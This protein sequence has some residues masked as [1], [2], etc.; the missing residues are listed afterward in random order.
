MTDKRIRTLADWGVIAVFLTALG[1]P[2]LGAVLD[3]PFNKTNDMRTLSD[4]PRLRLKGSVLKS[5]PA[6]F[7]Q[8]WSDHFGFRGAL[9]QALSVARIHWLHAP[10]SAPVQIGRSSW[11]YYAQQ[12]P[13]MDYERVRPFT[14]E[15]LDRWQRVLEQRCEWLRQ[16][17]CRYLLFIPPDKQTIYPEYVDPRYRPKTTATRLEQL[18]TH[19]RNHRAKVDFLDIR[20]ELFAAKRSERLYHRTDSHWN[21]Y[22]AFVGYQQLA[23]ALTKWFP[24]I[25]PAPRGAFVQV[26]QN[27]GG[28][29]LA[30]ILSLKEWDHE[31]WLRL[32][33]RSPLKARMIREGIARPVNVRVPMAAPFASECDDAR[34]PRAVVFHDSFFL[35]LAPLMA[36]HF[37]RAVYIWHDDFHADVVERERPDVVIHEMLERKLAD[38]TPNE[39]DEESE[40]DL[41]GSP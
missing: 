25:R 33:P 39:V 19:L 20:K 31:R 11:L 13:G 18:V 12:L 27:G 7:E 22:G 41:R 3:N 5:F 40:D 34:L 36:E 32:E 37:R 2:L 29:D 4:F 1:L 30:Q 24:I 17:K 28:G 6:R 38:V 14:E 35:A 15:E 26:E 23:G 10:S 8:F 16:R 21:D 9:I